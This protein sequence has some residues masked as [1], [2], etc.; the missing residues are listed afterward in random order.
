M[1]TYHLQFLDLH[2]QLVHARLVYLNLLVLLTK[3]SLVVTVSL[4]VAAREFFE[5][6]S[7]VLR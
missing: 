3:S 2:Q 1:G 4:G 7:F 5:G 6:T